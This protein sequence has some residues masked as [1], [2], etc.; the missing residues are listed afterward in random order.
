MTA[1]SDPFHPVVLT[2]NG[3]SYKRSDQGKLC[4]KLFDKSFSGAQSCQIK[5]KDLK[6]V[7]LHASGCTENLVVRVV[8]QYNLW[9]ETAP[10][11]EFPS[12]LNGRNWYSSSLAFR[13]SNGSFEIDVAKSVLTVK[14]TSVTDESIG[15]Q[16]VQAIMVETSA[17][18]GQFVEVLV[19]E[20]SFV[21]SS[22]RAQRVSF[23]H[24]EERKR[25]SQKSGA[26]IFSFAPED[27]VRV[28]DLVKLYGV[29]QSVEL[30]THPTGAAK[31]DRVGTEERPV[32]KGLKFGEAEHDVCL[33]RFWFFPR[34]S[35]GAMFEWR[36]SIGSG[37]QI[38]YEKLSDDDV[39]DS[40][41]L[42]TNMGTESQVYTN[43]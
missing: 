12:E 16:K 36:D 26:T 43:S 18:D 41:T 17:A 29:A 38:V 8:T 31:A 34:G 21:T 24:P 1:L 37:I 15:E 33:G 3:I 6:S 23:A 13:G 11:G 2:P 7:V 40:F 28:R 32:L 30:K 10:N 35:E 14:G 27:D 19:R 22:G 42:T 9:D 25:V 39:V 5:V 20:A 4:V